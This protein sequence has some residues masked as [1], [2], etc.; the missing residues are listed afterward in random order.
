MGGNW[1]GGGE[2]ELSRALRTFIFFPRLH[3]GDAIE[4]LDLLASR[5]SFLVSLGRD[6]RQGQFDML[7][8]C[9]VLRWKGCPKITSFFCQGKES[10]DFLVK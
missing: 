2:R 3:C 7:G 1:G 6:S 9:R 4:R 8:S 10:L 5:V